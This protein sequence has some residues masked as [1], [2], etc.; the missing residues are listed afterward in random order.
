MSDQKPGN[1]VKAGQ[2]QFP[3]LP[4]ITSGTGV[5]IGGKSASW[6][7]SVAVDVKDAH[8]VNMNNSGLCE[9]GIK[10]TERNVGLASTGPF[11]GEWKNGNVP[12]S[13][14]RVWLPIAPG[15][16]NGGTDLVGL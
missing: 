7:S 6:G 10:H 1:V 9:F 4:D 15:G 8:S 12:G 13:W 11:D 16:S 2:P 14:G 5:V 3:N